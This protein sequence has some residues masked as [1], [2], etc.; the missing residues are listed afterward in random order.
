[1]WQGKEN[2]KPGAPSNVLKCMLAKKPSGIKKVEK[3]MSKF[4]YVSPIMHTARRLTAYVRALRS[5]GHLKNGQPGTE[6]D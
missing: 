1:M 5:A 2:L 4:A 3:Q 6:A